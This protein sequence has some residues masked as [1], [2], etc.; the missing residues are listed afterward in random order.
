MSAKNKKE[1]YI[2]L[3]IMRILAIYAVIFNHSAKDGFFLFSTRPV[4]S[5]SFWVYLFISVSCKFA[6][7]V[8]FAISGALM[9]NRPNESMKALWGVRIRNIAI[10][11]FVYSAFY[12]IYHA[13]ETGKAIDLKEFFTTLYSSKTNPQLWYLYTYIAFLAVLPFLRA[14]VT[15]L[16]D[17]YFYYLIVIV[18][19][20][21]G[22]LPIVEY[23]LS[24][25]T[26]TMNGQ[27]KI[28]WL[29]G[30][31]VLYPS[32]G[33]FMQHRITKERIKK[34][35][36]WLIVI[37]IVGIGISCYMTYYKGLLEGI[38]SEAQS[39]TFYYSF[40]VLTCITVFMLIRLLFED[41]EVNGCF[42]R[43]VLSVGSCT[44]GIFLWHLLF[45]KTRYFYNGLAALKSLGLDDMI[46]ALIMCFVVLLVSYL[47][48]LVQS[49]IPV[50]KKLVGF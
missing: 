21:R 45:E 15:N 30:Y 12:Y 33:Y 9:L 42:R 18:L 37:N 14:L 26:I 25:G 38:F 11:L 36:P 22:F 48:T 29:M 46:C 40:V 16:D 31:T 32:L 50:L 39:Q 43:M 1:K 35:I 2:H 19:F 20:F 27:L 5:L 28:T 23:L 7:P 4:G 3:E 10:I 24:Q 44:F 34:V 47:V 8:F 13:I 41:R 17:K 6:V 49:K